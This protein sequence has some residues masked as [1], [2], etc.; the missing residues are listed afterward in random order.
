VLDYCRLSADPV[1]RLLLHLFERT[2]PQMLGWSDRICS[3]LQLI[4]FLQDIAVD[5]QKGRVY[6]AQDEL[7][8]AGID[9]RWIS[10]GRVDERWC[11]FMTAQ[12]DRAGGM[13]ASGAPLARALPGRVG[14]ELRMI[15]SG[16]A[17][18]VHRLHRVRGDV[19]RHRPQLGAADWL[20][21]LGRTLWFPA[22]PPVAGA[23]PAG[24]IR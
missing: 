16:G 20:A 5:W 24:A 4:N 15:V 13:L 12:I 1:G 8:A 23:S 7:A 2:E 17:R 11:S 14:I 21:I 22:A 10:E 19:F 3:A 6:L 9:E 18:I